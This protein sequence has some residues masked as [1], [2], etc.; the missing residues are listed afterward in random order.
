MQVAGRTASRRTTCS[1]CCCPTA[2]AATTCS[3][4]CASPG[5]SAT[6]HYLPLHASDAGRAFAARPTG[7]PGDRGRQR[8]GCCGCRST[9]TSASA[10]STGRSRRSSRPCVGHASRSER[11]MQPDRQPGSSSLRQPGLL[12]APRPR[13]PA[14]R[15]VRARPRRPAAHPRRRQRGRAERRLDARRPP[16]RDA[17]TCCPRGWCPGEGVCGSATALPFADATFDVVARLRRRRALRGRRAAP[18]SELA[19]V[20]APGGRMLLSVP[21]YQWAW[22]RPRRPGRAPPPLHAAAAGPAGRGGRDD[23]AAG[24]VRLRRRCSRSSSPSALRRRLRRPRRP[25]TPAPAGVAARRPGA[26]GPVRG[27]TG[28]VLRRARPAVRLVGVRWPRS[29]PA[30]SVARD[31]AAR[32]PRAPP[33]A[34]TSATRKPPTVRATGATPAER[35]TSAER[36]GERPRTPRPA[37]AASGRSRA[38]ATTISTRLATAMVQPAA[39]TAACRRDTSTVLPEDEPQ[40]RRARAARRQHRPAATATTRQPRQAAHQRPQRGRAARRDVRG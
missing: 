26:D 7:V 12:V 1:T 39:S 27:W 31:R 38:S 32:R 35:T 13:R 29:S 30:R 16:A 2:T 37:T 20:L 4:R 8:T 15:G 33:A 14:P 6:F 36:P 5:C 10:T 25:A 23:G 24:D 40:Q 3:R 22:S 21:A 19:R 28:G 17:S 9:T 34:A 18:S 11:R